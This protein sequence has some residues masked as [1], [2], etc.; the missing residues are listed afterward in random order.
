MFIKKKVFL[1]SFLSFL[2]WLTFSFADNDEF[3][4]IQ[5]KFVYHASLTQNLKILKPYQACHGKKWVYAAPNLAVA[6]SFL[7]SASDFDFGIG[8]DDNGVFSITE[9]YKGAFDLY[10]GMSGS[11]YKLSSDGFLSN[12]TTWDLEVVNPNEVQIL[13]EKPIIDAFDFLK[14]LEAAGRLK[15]YYFPNRPSC[16]PL[17]DSDIIIK[18]V[19]WTRGSFPNAGR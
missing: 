4:V 19:L 16:F 17:D 15:L 13:E 14:Q 5:S 6:T 12:Q 7:T 10:K 3:L 2:V 9:R 11:I 1:C 8:I 18:A